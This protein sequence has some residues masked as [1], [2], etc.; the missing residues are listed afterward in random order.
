MTTPGSPPPSDADLRRER[1]TLRLENEALREALARAED[2]ARQA[3]RLAA[4]LEAD[5]DEAAQERAHLAVVIQH[6]VERTG[7]IV[8][9]CDPQGRIVRVNATGL[10]FLGP[11]AVR[12]GHSVLDE[13]LHEDDRAAFASDL[14]S[15][16]WRV[17][18]PFA[19]AMYRSGR[20]ERRHHLRDRS[21]QLAEFL[22]EAAPLAGRPGHPEGI[23]VCATETS[24]G[25]V[26][27]AEPESPLLGEHVRTPLNAVVGLAQLLAA[28]AD[29]TARREYARTLL[30]ASRDLM[31]A[32]GIPRELPHLRFNM[33]ERWI[34][35]GRGDTSSSTVA[36]LRVLVA[37]DNAINVRVIEGMLRYLGCEATFVANGQQAVDALAEGRTFD[38][39]LMDI[40]MPEL[41]GCEATRQIR[42]NEVRAGRRRVPIVAVSAS[43]QPGERERYAEAGIDDVLAKPLELGRLHDVLAQWVKPQ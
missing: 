9:V 5:L 22:V 36:G 32:L 10:S 7:A 17:S 27:R 8:I 38:I 37:E 40:Q 21:G 15:L 43:V 19:E 28:G 25:P 4:R 16:P 14:P 41:D 1:E 39:V 23:L 12:E 20:Y 11:D 26:L 34:D 24:P 42:R 35:R 29:D 13:W 6:L 2:T 33:V 18:S 30:D 31:E 3:T